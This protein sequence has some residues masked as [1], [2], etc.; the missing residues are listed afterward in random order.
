MRNVSKNGECRSPFISYRC[1]SD[2]GVKCLSLSL[3]AFYAE[4][5]L[6]DKNRIDAIHIIGFTKMIFHISFTLI[7][8]NCA[9]GFVSDYVIVTDI[10]LF[11]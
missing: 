6:F 7:R 11:V 5:S 8:V 9:F 2:V 3:C 4:D 10:M 1:S